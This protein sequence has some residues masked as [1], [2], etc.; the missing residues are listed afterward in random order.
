[1]HAHER[2]ITKVEKTISHSPAGGFQ[3]SIRPVNLKL[4]G[5]DP[6]LKAGVTEFE[7]VFPPESVDPGRKETRGLGFISPWCSVEFWDGGNKKT[8]NLALKGLRQVDTFF[9]GYGVISTLSFDGDGK[10]RPGGILFM[11]FS[12]KPTKDTRTA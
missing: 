2:R 12:P 3:G 8:W 10:C 4:D 9:K 7:Y 6:K 11:Q 1:M 5:E